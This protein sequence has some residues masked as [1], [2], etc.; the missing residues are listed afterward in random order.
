[1]EA[2]MRGERAAFARL[3]SELDAM[4]DAIA[5]VKAHLQGDTIKPD[6][7]ANGNSI[8][9][10]ALLD[11]LQLRIDTMREF[12]AA[13][14]VPA[15][16]PPPAPAAEL[17]M[18]PAA[19]AEGERD[20]A[21]NAAASAVPAPAAQDRVPTVSGV[22]SRLGRTSETL[23]PAADL[24][25]AAP[26]PEGAG[27]V[28]TVSMLE[29]MVEALT[30]SAP[31]AEQNTN[32]G[33]EAVSEADGDPAAFLFE[34]EPEPELEPDSADFLLEQKPSPIATGSAPPQPEATS[35]EEQHQPQSDVRTPADPLA[36][37]KAMSPEEKIALFS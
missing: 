32:S 26:A 13:R 35:A 30:A 8:V 36:P 28:P 14:F 24:V 6:A 34:P 3:H 19:Q 9:F 21:A 25:E 17:P 2:A 23:M 11:E 7:A 12:A 1:M 20:A 16:E 18:Q 33:A 29:A 37:L 4:A 15:C 10:A 27:G 31:A 5:H 22:V